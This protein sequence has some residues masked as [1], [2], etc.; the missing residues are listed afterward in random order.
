MTNVELFLFS[1]KHPEPMFDP[2]YNKKTPL[3]IPST[4][5]ETN[6]LVTGNERMIKLISAFDVL[7][8]LNAKRSDPHVEEILREIVGILDSTEGINLSAFAQ[9]FMVY[10]SSHDIYKKYGYEERLIFVHEMLTKFCKERHSVYLSH[11]YSNTALQV[12]A[13]NYSHKRNSKT[14]IVKVE[15]RLKSAGF[16]KVSDIVSARG[17]AYLLPDKGGKKGFLKFKKHFAIEFLSAQNEQDKLPDMVLKIEDDYYVAELKN[18][19]GSGGGQDKQITEVVNFIRYAEKNA[20]IHYLTFL[21]GDYFNILTTSKQP[22]IQK[23][24][25]DILDSLQRHSGNYFVNT[26]GFIQFLDERVCSRAS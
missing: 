7:R 18:M 5:S 6:A 20:S 24:Y 16:Q 8:G 17:C 3:V 23:Q 1:G 11:G 21:D 25:K 19:K 10:S 12:V 15:D 9:F 14:S 26:A 22:K 2:Y 4:S 13:D